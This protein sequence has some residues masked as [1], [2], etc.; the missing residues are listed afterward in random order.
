MLRAWKAFGGGL[1]SP[2]WLRGLW[3]PFL[4]TCWLGRLPLP[5]VVLSTTWS[6]GWPYRQ[7]QPLYALPAWNWD[8]LCRQVCIMG[9]SS[10][11][12]DSICFYLLLPSFQ[13]SFQHTT[14]TSS[15][16]W[17]GQYPWG[18]SLFALWSPIVTQSW[19]ASFIDEFV[20]DILDKSAWPTWHSSSN[21]VSCQADDCAS[22]SDKW[23]PD[24]HIWFLERHRSNSSGTRWSSDY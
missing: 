15:L 12:R 7:F 6:V 20:L 17:S 21:I 2:V 10:R 23:W 13:L 1:K 22:F 4:P 8:Y 14:P 9:E 24:R 16:G 11:Q 3:G 5:L 18:D 19:L